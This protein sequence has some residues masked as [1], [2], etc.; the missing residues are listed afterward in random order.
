MDPAA[1]TPPRQRRAVDAEFAT[2]VDEPVLVWLQPSSHHVQLGS[3]RLR[4]VPFVDQL[5]YRFPG[6]LV[7]TLLVPASGHV[8]S[9]RVQRLGDPRRGATGL[10]QRCDAFLQARKIV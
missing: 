3:F 8:K 6:M 7:L 5:A 9:F 10:P 4:Y 1:T 2:E